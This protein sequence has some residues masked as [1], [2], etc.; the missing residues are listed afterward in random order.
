MH[1]LSAQNSLVTGDF[2]INRTRFCANIHVSH[3]CTSYRN[4]RHENF[5]ISVRISSKSTF[6]Y[7]EFLNTHT[8]LHYYLS[9][10]PFPPSAL[11]HSSNSLH[12]PDVSVNLTMCRLGGYTQ[13]FNVSQRPFKKYHVATLYIF[14]QLSFYLIFGCEWHHGWFRKYSNVPLAQIKFLHDHFQIGVHQAVHDQYR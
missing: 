8:I 6:R 2:W 5:W 12:S 1:R 14:T 4:W 11:S 13:R 3:C 7:S 10:R 9:C